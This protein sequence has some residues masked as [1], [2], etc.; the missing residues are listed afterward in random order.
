M[1]Q[2]QVIPWEKGTSCV[3]NQTVLPLSSRGSPLKT[4]H[5]KAEANVVQPQIS[6]QQAPTRVCTV[7]QI[8]DLFLG[9]PNGTPQTIPWPIPG[10]SQFLWSWYPCLGCF[11]LG[12]QQ[13]QDPCAMSFFVGAPNKCVYIYI[14]FCGGASK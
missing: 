6:P 2:V 5:F 10:F 8:V 12:R 3:F 4:Q 9:K 7:L 13:E 14:H 1:S 11:F